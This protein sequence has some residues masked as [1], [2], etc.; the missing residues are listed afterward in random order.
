MFFIFCFPGLNSLFINQ[1]NYSNPFLW[2]IYNSIFLFEF[3]ILSFTGNPSIFKSFKYLIKPES[4]KRV[5]IFESIYLWISFLFYFFII[6][7]L[8]LNVIKMK[9]AP[10][11][12]IFLSSN[13]KLPINIRIYNRSQAYVPMYTNIRN[14]LSYTRFI[15]LLNLLFP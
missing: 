1:T 12:L 5:N 13:F 14:E 8:N 4:S 11:T 6:F 3:V 7:F 9:Y 15:C 10:M 2:R